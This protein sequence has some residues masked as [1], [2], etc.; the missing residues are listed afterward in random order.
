MS[1]K[2]RNSPASKKEPFTL[3]DTLLLTILPIVFGIAGIAGIDAA[4]PVTGF[5]IGS[6]VFLVI[7]AFAFPFYSKRNEIYYSKLGEDT[8]L[9]ISL[10]FML[11]HLNIPSL[12][13]VRENLFW[14]LMLIFIWLVTCSTIG[15]VYL[16]AKGKIS[17][18]KYDN[19]K[20]YYNYFFLWIG[21]ISCIAFILAT[22]GYNRVRSQ[23][24]DMQPPA[25]FFFGEVTGNII[26]MLSFSLAMT[27]IYGYGFF[28]TSERI[29]NNLKEKQ[30][31]NA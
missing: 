2:K 19:I 11:L 13:L 23:N 14:F 16:K 4:Q 1:K 26:I 7:L 15:I 21:I 22:L 9:G 24:E 20:K 29:M 30:L 10:F 31:K 8:I 25:E 12:Y 18:S 5:I 6:C 28:M 3:S 17:S 27:I